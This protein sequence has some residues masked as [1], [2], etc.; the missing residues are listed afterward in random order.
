M[1]LVTGAFLGVTVAGFRVFSRFL[2]IEKARAERF[3]A[4]HGPQKDKERK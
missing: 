1:I 4:I 3:R 2:D